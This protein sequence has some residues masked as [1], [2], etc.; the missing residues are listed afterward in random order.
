MEQPDDNTPVTTKDADVGRLKADLAREHEKYLRALA[1]FEN[2]RK[3]TERDRAKTAAN[4]KRELLL[5]LLGVL[6]SF[7]RALPYLSTGL[8]S[9]AEGVQAIH[10]SLEDLFRAQKVTSFQAVGEPFDPAVH[11]AV[12]AVESREYPPGTVTEEVRRGYRLE[13]DVLR[14][15]QVRVAR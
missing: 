1:D 8:P 5:S 6:D 14:P 7:D 9:V 4:A 15:A 12:G 11:E 13:N 2:Y 10:R 3:R